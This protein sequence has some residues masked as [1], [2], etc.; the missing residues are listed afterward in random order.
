FAKHPKTWKC[1]LAL[2]RDGRPIK[3]QRTIFSECF[4]A[5][6]FSELAISTG[7]DEYRVEALS[8]MDKI[9][10]WVREDPTDLL[11]GYPPMAGE[12]EV[13]PLNV[14]MMI[15]CLVDQMETMDTELSERY[16]EIAE[17]SVNQIRAHIQRNGTVILENVDQEGR[18][19]PGSSGRVMVPAGW[20]LLNYAIKNGRPELADTAINKFMIKPFEYGW[21][22]E[23]GGLFYFLDAD[24]LSPVQLEWNMKLWWTHNEAM[25]AFLMAYQH[26]GR[27]EILKKF[28]QVFD[29]VYAKHVDRK[30]GEW[31]GY[32]NRDGTVCMDFKGGPWKGIYYYH[33]MCHYITA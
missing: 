9:I 30:Y 4:Y 31:F 2:T 3:M 5:M 15:L 14:P 7:H 33:N 23:H 28:E 25:I 22:K 1:Y 29:Y 8:M 11:F 26:T 12:P 27:L 16:A 13:N 24:G 6:A 32:L 10:Y 19:L 17:W 21:D 18:E 20:F